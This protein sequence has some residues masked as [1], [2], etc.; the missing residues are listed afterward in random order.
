M[1]KE[2]IS[3]PTMWVLSILVV[4]LCSLGLSRLTCLADHFYNNLGYV[5]LNR[6]VSAAPG[7]AE[8]DEVA[9]LQR[10]ERLFSMGT[11]GKITA[12]GRAYLLLGATYQRRR[13]YQDA[14]R[15]YQS[16]T[17]LDFTQADKIG[18]SRLYYELGWL[19]DHFVGDKVAADNAYK[20]AAEIAGVPY[21]GIDADN[22]IKNGGFEYAGLYWGIGSPSG[23]KTCYDTMET[24]SGCQSLQIRFDGT[25]D[26]NYYHAVTFVPVEPSTAYTLTLYV[27][28]LTMDASGI[29]AEVYDADRGYKYWYGGN[30]VPLSGTNDWTKM[31]VNFVSG[32]DTYNLRV[33][34]RRFG[35]RGP[36]A[37]GTVWIDNVRLIQ[38]GE[39]HT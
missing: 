11:Q 16:A 26:V 32:I 33:V 5:M 39:G 14:L 28:T 15:V 20:K 34:L 12:T 22:L 30:T 36:I 10:A 2:G 37:S 24:R 13:D 31:T 21:N 9:Y 1:V 7:L 29:A 38:G 25:Q 3:A 27:K 6:A 23:A 8:S 18:M 17:D 19:Y 35:G 4:F